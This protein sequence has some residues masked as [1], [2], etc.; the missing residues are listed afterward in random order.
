MKQES[1]HYIPGLLI[2]RSNTISVTINCAAKGQCELI[3]LT[4]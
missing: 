2:K 3:V 4:W 1:G